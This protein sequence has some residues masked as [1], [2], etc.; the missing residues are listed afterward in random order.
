MT[1]TIIRIL[2]RI[3][4]QF[5]IIFNKGILQNNKHQALDH[6]NI[7]AS[8]CPL[9]PMNLRT[10][11]QKNGLIIRFSNKL[12]YIMLNLNL[13]FG[14]PLYVLKLLIRYKMVS[15][16]IYFILLIQHTAINICIIKNKYF[17]NIVTYYISYSDWF[18]A[19]L[20]IFGR[21]DTFYT[22]KIGIRWLHFLFFLSILLNIN[23][24]Y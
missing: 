20:L 15:N 8:Q 17:K 12:S 18:S 24:N 10:H 13:I 4:S 2:I 5:F 23:I 21:R 3:I 1:T 11:L 16:L 22:V 9:Y 14:L 19:M 7:P 6:L